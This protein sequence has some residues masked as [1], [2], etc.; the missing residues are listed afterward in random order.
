M[1]AGRNGRISTNLADTPIRRNEF[2]KESKLALRQAQGERET[3]NE[4]KG[5][6][7]R[8]EPFDFAQDALVEARFIAPGRFF[9]K[10]NVLC[11]SLRGGSPRTR[12]DLT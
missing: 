12:A 6:T 7:A 10:L 1:D 4:F 2:V 3:R 8:A 11:F 5:C 9:H